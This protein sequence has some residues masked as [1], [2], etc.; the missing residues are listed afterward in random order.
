MKYDCKINNTIELSEERRKHILE[1]HPDL[2]PYFSKIAEVLHNPDQIRKSKQ[3][4]N[5][6]LFYKF[7]SDVKDGKYITVVAKF[8]KTNFILTSYITDKIKTGDKIYEK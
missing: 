5:V 8:N 4:E 3:D 1:F 7:F 6:L 2:K